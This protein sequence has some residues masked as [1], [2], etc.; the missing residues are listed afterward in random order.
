M[1]SNF[2]QHRAKPSS[3]NKNPLLNTNFFTFALQLNA[4]PIS[5]RSASI[6]VCAKNN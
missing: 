5:F 2:T 3:Q 4:H 6:C 1:F